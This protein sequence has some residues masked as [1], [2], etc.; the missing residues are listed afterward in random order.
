M[1]W[2]RTD[3]TKPKALLRT[4]TDFQP[5]RLTVGN[6]D[7]CYS[8]THVERYDEEGGPLIQDIEFRSPCDLI[9]A[10]TARLRPG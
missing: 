2:S 7:K 8:E 6:G 5:Q 10:G 4:E 1:T 3:A 9:R